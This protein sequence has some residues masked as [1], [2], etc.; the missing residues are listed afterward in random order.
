VA[1]W[2]SASIFLSTCF[3]YFSRCLPTALFPDIA[4]SRM[5]NANSLFLIL[6]PIHE[7]RL[8]LSF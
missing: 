4:P 3:K 2:L 6:C 8:F 1:L 7:W 5:F